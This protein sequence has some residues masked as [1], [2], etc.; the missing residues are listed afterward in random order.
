MNEEGAKKLVQLSINRYGREKI[1]SHLDVHLRTIKRWEDGLTTVPKGNLIA[2][3]QLS[4]YYNSNAPITGD[5]TF[6][7]L[8]AGIGGI[9]R[10]F[11]AH[12]G[13]C[14]MTC[15]W[16]S[17]ARKTYEANFPIEP[18]HT[19]ICDVT[20]MTHSDDEI[21]R[22]V[23]EHDVLLAGFPCQPFSIAGVSKKNSLGRKHGFAC[24]E[25]GNLFFN[26]ADI[27]RVQRPPAFLLEN[28]K[29]LQSHDKGKTFKIIKETLEDVLGYKIYYKVIDAK[30]FVPQH[31]ERIFIVGFD[32][33]TNFTWNDLQLPPSDRKKMK[34]IL[35]PENGQEYPEEPYTINSE[36]IVNPK[37]TLSDKL[38]DYLQAY[39]KKHREKGNGFG[40]GLV[41]PEDTSRTLSARYYKDGSEILVSRGENNNPRRL[42]PRECA[43][44]MGFDDKFKI[45]VSDTRAYKQFGNCVVT[46][47]IEEIARIMNPHILAMKTR[48]QAQQEIQ[49]I[50]VHG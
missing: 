30:G 21:K 14:L 12:S 49:D 4:L 41:G 42:T 50:A 24:Q 19:F 7:D 44:L 27:I 29:N 2:L 39:A 36:S 33:E 26:V 28:V 40:F 11:E 22:F 35:H 8:F 3:E 20:S 15:E 9:R 5:F 32:G 34:D 23:P 13:Q 43:R 45:P 46:S 16:D 38:W 31:R 10:G 6:I 1:A 37:Y 17:Y 18:N 48:N 47:L 25:Q